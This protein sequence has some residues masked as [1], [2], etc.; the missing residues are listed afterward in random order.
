MDVTTNV[1]FK[2]VKDDTEFVF[3]MPAQAGLGLAYDAAHDVMQKIADHA[4]ELA[5]A[6]KRKAEE[7]KDKKAK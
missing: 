5:E 6:S 2:V 4:K 7:P 3:S 1:A